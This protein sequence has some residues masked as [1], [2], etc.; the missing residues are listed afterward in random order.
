MFIDK[1]DMNSV[2]YIDNISFM[3]ALVNLFNR[4]CTG[5]I[6]FIDEL[7]KNVLHVVMGCDT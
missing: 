6:Q 3:C 2:L 4:M 5:L 7:L 1:F